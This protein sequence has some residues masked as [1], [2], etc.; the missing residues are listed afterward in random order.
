MKKFDIV[1]LDWE[2]RY[3][4]RSLGNTA[5]RK[6]STLAAGIALTVFFYGILSLLRARWSGVV[7]L[8]MFFPGGSAGRSFIPVITVAV[9]M[10]TLSMLLLKRSKVK[11]QQSALKA[12]PEL[13]AADRKT[14]YQHLQQIY[15]VP[16]DFMAAAARLKRAELEERQLNTVELNSVM[17]SCFNDL[18][19]E[20]EN[21]FIPI[22]CFIWSIPVL[23]FIGTVL[24]LAQAVS[25]FGALS[26]A[27]D[28]VN[29]DAVL[30]QI[31]GGLATAFETTLIALVLALLLQVFASFQNQNELALIGA[32][33]N[34]IMQD[35]P[36]GTSA[37]N[38]LAAENTGR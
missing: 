27:G 29:F 36:A 26:G 6:T 8:E 13:P 34:K 1:K 19:K 17:E 33:K 9:A 18:E 25:N 10:W 20:S 24:G 5:V 12:L 32:I 23:G 7:T 3:G 11:L 38:A 35:V 21:T 2:E 16:E 22:S 31:T 4:M 14:I 30:P 37:A 28:K 15:E